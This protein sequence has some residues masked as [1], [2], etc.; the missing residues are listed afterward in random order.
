MFRQIDKS[1]PSNLINFNVA[2]EYAVNL[3]KEKLIKYTDIYKIVAKISSLNLNYKLK[4]INDI[5]KYH[6]LL[7]RKIDENRFYFN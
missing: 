6:K 1:D 2:N 4:N 3:F 7:E 5:I